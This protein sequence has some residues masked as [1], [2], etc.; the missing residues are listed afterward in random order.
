MGEPLTDI[1]TSP[2]LRLRKPGV[3]AV[4]FFGSNFGVANGI[5]DR[6]ARGV[7]ATT[8]EAD[9]LLGGSIALFFALRALF[10]TLSGWAFSLPFL[11]VPFTAV[12]NTVCSSSSSSSS[13]CASGARAASTNG[14]EPY[15][16][17]YSGNFKR[18]TFFGTRKILSLNAFVRASLYSSAIFWILAHRLFTIGIGEKECK[19]QSWHI[20]MK[21]HYGPKQ[22]Y[23]HS[24]SI[25]SRRFST[26]EASNVCSCSAASITAAVVHLPSG[27]TFS[28]S[29]CASVSAGRFLPRRALSPLAGLDIFAAAA[30]GVGLQRVFESPPCLQQWKPLSK[31]RLRQT[32]EKRSP[33]LLEPIT[34][35]KDLKVVE[36]LNPKIGKGAVGTY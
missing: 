7:A 16:A 19:C 1:I 33:F 4:T 29:F 9:I 30:Y 23:L 20:K 34:G 31:L 6:V 13:F 8:E 35:R 12:C 24:L 5:C 10:L 18:C 17:T 36:I 11:R 25:P 22:I 3:S 32:V 26:Y 14:N 27:A 2:S 21:C 28:S 15:V